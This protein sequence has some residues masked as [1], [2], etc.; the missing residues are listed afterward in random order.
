M[1][2]S[3]DLINKSLC[4]EQDRKEQL[5]SVMELGNGKQAE[6]IKLLPELTDELVH[7]KSLSDSFYYNFFKVMRIVV[8]FVMQGAL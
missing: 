6:F 7:F 4:F 2:Q 1:F 8:Y 5:M 3:A